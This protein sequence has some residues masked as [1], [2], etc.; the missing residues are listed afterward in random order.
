MEE[1]RKAK[2][3]KAE[4]EKNE[5]ILADRWRAKVYCRAYLIHRTNKSS[6][7]K[8]RHSINGTK[9]THLFFHRGNQKFS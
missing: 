2:S 5:N 8:T 6:Y 4:R 1:A 9:K 7:I 3:S